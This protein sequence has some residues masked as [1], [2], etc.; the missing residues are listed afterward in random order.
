MAITMVD[1]IAS[2]HHQRRGFTTVSHPTLAFATNEYY[3]GTGLFLRS[4]VNARIKKQ[5]SLAALFKTKQW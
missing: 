2:L 1:L 4:S 3:N 5:S